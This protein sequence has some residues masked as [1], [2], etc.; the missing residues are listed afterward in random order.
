MANPM[1]KSDPPRCA[2][3]FLELVLTRIR[4]GRRMLRSSAR[5]LFNKTVKSARKSDERIRRVLGPDVMVCVS[6]TDLAP[7]QS[8]KDILER[9]RATGR[10]PY[11]GIVLVLRDQSVWRV[12]GQDVAMVD[13]G[14]A[15]AD[16]L[17][18]FHRVRGEQD[19]ASLVA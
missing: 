3:P 13:D 5:R 7:G 18:L 4:Y 1:M 14:D 16:G 19:A 8:D 17:G 12:G 2:V 6:V 15:V 11:A 9:H 10:L